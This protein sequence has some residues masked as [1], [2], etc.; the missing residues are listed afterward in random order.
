MGESR[1]LPLLSKLQVSKKHIQIGMQEVNH[2]DYFDMMKALSKK[3]FHLLRE[4]NRHIRKQKGSITLPV[5][6]M[7]SIYAGYVLT[8]YNSLHLIKYVEEIQKI[9][10]RIGKLEVVLSIAEK[11]RFIQQEELKHSLLIFGMTLKVQN[12]SEKKSANKKYGHHF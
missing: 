2:S 12:N 10:D 6:D 4:P 11:K 1:K 8:N 7:K 5:K 3:K 9:Q